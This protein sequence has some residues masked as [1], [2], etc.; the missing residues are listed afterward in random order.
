MCT[1]YSICTSQFVHVAYLCLTFDPVLCSQSSRG[2]RR[3]RSNTTCWWRSPGASER[4]PPAASWEEAHWP[5]PQPAAATASWPPR[6]ARP[7]CPRFSSVCRPPAATRWETWPGVG[8]NLCFNSLPIGDWDPPAHLRFSSSGG[9]KRPSRQWL[10]PPAGVHGLESRGG[11]FGK[12]PKHHLELRAAAQ[13]RN[14]EPS[15]VRGRHVFHLRV[16]Q[17]QEARTGR[18]ARRRRRRSSPAFILA[19]SAVW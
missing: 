15:G 9:N 11:R 13:R 16:P 7:V 14:V 12:V 17:E 5:R 19:S 18:M 6:S 10:Q 1:F 2:W 8:A 3:Q 4:R